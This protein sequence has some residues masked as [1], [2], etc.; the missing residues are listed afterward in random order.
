V[1]LGR[2]N[3]GR[4]FD[5]F[6]YP[7]L[8]A[9]QEQSKLLSAVAGWRITPLSFAETRE[10]ERIMG[11]AASGSY[12]Q[13]FGLRPALGRFFTPEED[14]VPG[15]NPVVVLSF[16]FWQDRFSG[17]RAVLG[18]TI[19]INRR[20]FTVIGVAP[21]ISSDT[22]PSCAPTCISRSRCLALRAR[23]LTRGRIGSPAG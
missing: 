5:T 21:A 1:E 19:D 12:F 4:G 22:C 3:G 9:I 6:G 10:S 13:V 8:L 2:S 17:D 11:M 15:A 20:Q 23:D 14:R 7:E 18:R 16:Q